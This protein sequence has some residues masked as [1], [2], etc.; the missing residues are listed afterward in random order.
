MQLKDR[1]TNNDRASK[2]SWP[3][4]GS[5]RLA[6]VHPRYFTAA[7]LLAG[8]ILTSL[9]SPTI[10]EE[11]QFPTWEN[12]VALTSNRLLTDIFPCVP[13]YLQMEKRDRIVVFRNL[14]NWLEA[15]AFINHP[16]AQAG[17]W[18][19]AAGHSLLAALVFGVVLPV[20]LPTEA[21]QSS[22]AATSERRQRDL[23]SLRWLFI[24]KKKKNTFK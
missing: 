16:A 1:S 14:H 4:P 20:A 8:L 9:E 24:I 2:L 19:G 5:S 15:V 6:H 3:E 23:D 7:Q 18:S 21:V 13:I 12:V 11:D 22:S 10:P 17:H